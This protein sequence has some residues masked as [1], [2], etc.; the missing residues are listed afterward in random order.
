MKVHSFVITMKCNCN[1]SR[2]YKVL[3]IRIVQF[4]LEIAVPLE[5]S[6]EYE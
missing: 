3:P 5:Y 2:L 1:S 6:T 4:Y